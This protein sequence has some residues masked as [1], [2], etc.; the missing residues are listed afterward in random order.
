MSIANMNQPIGEKIQAINKILE[1]LIEFVDTRANSRVNL[2]MWTLP[3]KAEGRLRY[4]RECRTV[5]FDSGR[6]S[7]K[8]TWAVKSSNADTLILTCHSN[9]RDSIKSMIVNDDSKRGQYLA[10]VWSNR[11]L[12][13]EMMKSKEE[14]Q[15]QKKFK[16]V[17]V[18]EASYFFDGLERSRFYKIIDQFV[19]VDTLFIFL[20]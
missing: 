14:H 17:I 20:G 2:T 1:S 4:F 19:T 6:Q 18:D 9:T 12:L 7:G 11:D 10:T 15:C 3:G 5:Q 8:T 13:T 16:R